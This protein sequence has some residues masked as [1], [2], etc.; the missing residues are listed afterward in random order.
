MT[1]RVMLDLETLSSKSNAVVVSDSSKH[2][3]AA[4]KF[5]EYLSSSKEMVGVRLDAG[6][7]LPAISDDTQ[8]KP[9]L[10]K[11]PPAN[12]KAVS[13]PSEGRARV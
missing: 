1:V 6:W 8:L 4:Q 9:Y 10:D 7:E 3:A 12:R 11:T 2:K 13:S 5:A